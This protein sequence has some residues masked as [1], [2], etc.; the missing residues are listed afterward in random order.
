M[1]STKGLRSS[2]YWSY[3]ISRR[4]PSTAQQTEIPSL[5]LQDQ[6]NL[7]PLLENASILLHHV[8]DS[9]ISTW[10]PE[11]MAFPLLNPSLQLNHLPEVDIINEEH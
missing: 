2:G 10:S 1:E 6:S 9:I 7:N 8:K 3:A 11:D 4:N 5:S